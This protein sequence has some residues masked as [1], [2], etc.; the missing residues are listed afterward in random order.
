M[1]MV[2]SMDRV[3]L[4]TSASKR[5]YASSPVVKIA[6]A[7][8]ARGGATAVPRKTAEKG[9]SAAPSI[10]RGGAEDV[11][12]FAFLR[13]LRPPRKRYSGIVT[14]GMSTSARSQARVLWD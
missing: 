14:K 2:K 12:R 8:P 7:W 11:G 4:C 5:A 10:S 6:N 9:D 1:N 3:A 13:N